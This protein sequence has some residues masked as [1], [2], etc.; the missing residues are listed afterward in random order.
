MIELKLIRQPT[1]KST[2]FGDLFLDMAWFCFTLEPTIRERPGV[3]VSIWKVAK[4]T[5]IPA[6]RY[7]LELYNSPR[8]GRETLQLV[9]VPGFSNVQIHVLNDD[10]ETEGCIGVGEAKLVDP[11]TDGGDLLRSR[12]ALQRLKERI[13][14]R[15]AAGEPC[16]LTISN[17][18]GALS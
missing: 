9:G 15:M 3:D 11:A 1:L 16:F 12:L 10:S 5:A 4:V 6:G 18:I 8:H 13:V 14:P 7:R 2:T 17:P